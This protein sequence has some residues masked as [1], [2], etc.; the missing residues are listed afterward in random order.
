MCRVEGDVLIGSLC[1]PLSLGQRRPSGVTPPRGWRGCESP[2]RGPSQGRAGEEAGA[3]L[4]SLLCSSQE[5]WRF[6]GPRQV[7]PGSWAQA[8]PAP[9]RGPELPQ[10]RGRGS[11]TI[12]TRPVLGS[13]TK[14]TQ[15]ALQVPTWAQASGLPAQLGGE[16]LQNRHLICFGAREKLLP[17]P[18]ALDCPRSISWSSR[19]AS[20]P[21][22]GPCPA[23][24]T[25]SE[26]GRTAHL[27]SIQTEGLPFQYR[28]T[29][30]ALS[31]LPQDGLSPA[32]PSALGPGLLGGLESVQRLPQQLLGE[33]RSRERVGLL[34]G[35]K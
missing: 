6:L 34:P 31:H 8:T 27:N 26:G 5:S 3:H 23:P 21:G 19:A 11:R 17:D 14:W 33:N 13:R 29:S 9:R 1:R 7:R 10:Q 20:A 30:F 18:L 32:P 2:G 35:G 15:T 28:G 4:C 16:R 12:S 25:C 24:R 22:T